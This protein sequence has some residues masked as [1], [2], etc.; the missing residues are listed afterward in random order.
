MDSIVIK[1]LK[2]Q[3]LV[4]VYPEER[5]ALRP[6][7]IDLSMDHDQQ[8]SGQSDSLE[9]TLDYHQISI[10]IDQF[11]RKSKYKLLEALAHHLLEALH[12]N[13]AISACRLRIYKPECVPFVDEIYI[14]Q[15]YP[16]TSNKIQESTHGKF[17]SFEKSHC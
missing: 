4:G 6:I 15:H 1:N 16:P 11:A 14:E 13:F 17:Q 10:F 7:R 3:T 8:K 2:T 9:D 12:T 5:K